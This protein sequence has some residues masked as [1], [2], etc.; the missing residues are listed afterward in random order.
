MNSSRVFL[1]H[2]KTTFSTVAENRSITLSIHLK[3]IPEGML[4]QADFKI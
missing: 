1:A 4:K 2:F 3:Q